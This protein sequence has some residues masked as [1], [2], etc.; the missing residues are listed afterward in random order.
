[1]AVLE[2]DNPPVNAL[3]REIYE[4]LHRLVDRIEADRTI[5]VVVFASAH[6]T[7]FAAGADLKRMG[8]DAFSRSAVLER[9]DRAQGAFLR[10]Q[11]LSKPTVAAIDGHALGG[12]CELALA[13]DFRFMRRGDAR[14][15]LPEVGLGLIPA[16]GGTQRLAR[17]VGRARAADLIMRGRRLDA[18][19]AE[20]IGLI[21]AGCDD[22]RAAALGRA[23]ELALMPAGALAAVKACLNDGVDGDLAR[24]LAVERSSALTTLT[25]PEAVEGVTAFLEHRPPDWPS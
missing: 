21:T 16:A 14:I 2:I 18:D 15:G 10:L 7:V 24:G 4:E 13:L 17:L 1:M 19:E 3:D 5:R 25:S 22:A 6:R 12:G 20:D 8:E 9:V 23:R 11:R